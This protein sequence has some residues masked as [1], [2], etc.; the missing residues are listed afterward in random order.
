V[1]GLFTALLLAAISP[2]RAEAQLAIALDGCG[3][4]NPL[5]VA[6]ALELE[7]GPS[8]GLSIRVICENGAV[9]IDVADRMT[10]KRVSRR[11]EGVDVARPGAAQVVA[12]LAS[13]LVLASWAELLLAPRGGAEGERARARVLAELRERDRAATPE[14]T[15][16]AAPPE[17]ATRSEAVAV[18]GMP[19]PNEG[20]PIT[21]TQ[22]PSDDMRVATET[23]TE[24]TTETTTEA[25][26]ETIPDVA[27]ADPTP[28][29]SLRLDLTGGV[30][31]RDLAAPFAPVVVALRGA[32]RVDETWS[33]GLRASVEI[34]EIARDA[35][36]VSYTA[37]GTGF[38]VG[39]ETLREDVFALDLFLEARGAWARLDARPARSSI[40]G[41]AL[42]AVLVELE[43]T[44]APSLVV[45]VFNL[46]LEASLGVTIIGPVGTVTAEPDVTLPG[47]FFGLGLAIG[48]R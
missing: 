20:A 31:L 19:T 38:I 14:A 6:A 26:T 41:R 22:A 42:D 15:S 30:H 28:H 2:A 7:L 9:S 27:V 13:E 48:L 36:T 25:T 23:T 29:A 44:L 3:S 8:V 46:A 4:V 33:I 11:V 32:A 21:Q 45:G 34:G 43:G 5:E 35:G 24:A 37:V 40:E 17:A 47:L 18:Q 39:L 10:D 1:V 16:T 12:L